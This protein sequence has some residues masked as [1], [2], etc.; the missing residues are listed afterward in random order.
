MI[1]PMDINQQCSNVLCNQPA[2]PIVSDDRCY[3]CELN[4][5]VDE[6]DPSK[7]HDYI[8]DQAGCREDSPSH[9]I[10]DYLCCWE[11]NKKANRISDILFPKN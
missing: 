9:V 2:D 4:D 1:N 6:S 11:D 10:T 3:E 8:I 7:L 5:R